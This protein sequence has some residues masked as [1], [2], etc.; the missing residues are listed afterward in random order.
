MFFVFI[1]ITVHL[2]RYNLY[3]QQFFRL[4]IFKSMIPETKKC[5]NH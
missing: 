1:S 3:K 4:E 2:N 5:K